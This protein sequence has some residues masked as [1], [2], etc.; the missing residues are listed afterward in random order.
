MTAYEKLL[1][2]Y[3]SIKEKMPF[4]P[5]V[6]VILGSGLGGFADKL[7]IEASI[8]YSEIEGFP[9]STAPL[10]KGRFV[11]AKINKVAAV[12]MQGRVHYY[13]GYSMQDVVLPTRLMGLMGIKALLLTNASGGINKQFS[14]GDFMLI[15]D[16]I[17]SFVPSPLIGEN[18][19][20]LGV[21]FPDMTDIYKQN[22]QN[23]ICRAADIEGIDLK[24]G[25]YL[26]TSG[27]AFESPA[28]VKM[29]GLLGADA[30]GMSTACEAI[31]ANHM[32]IGVAG[33]SCI[34]NMACGICEEKLTLEDVNI[35]A[36]RVGNVFCRLVAKSV[37]EIYKAVT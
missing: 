1:K 5:A 3:E 30:V 36:D 6:G 28:E 8:S 24:K 11:F 26:Q 18:I 7:E 35:I 9:V 33:I 13:E 22:L 17:S 29:F 16:Q 4:Q 2:C 27:P 37:E 32:G 19:D 14:A 23:A 12:I 20:K 15:K 34:S 25:V 10:H 31:T 21:R